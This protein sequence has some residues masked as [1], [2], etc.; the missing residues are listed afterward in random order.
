[1]CQSTLVYS[2]PCEGRLQAE[3][4]SVH[5]SSSTQTPVVGQALGPEI[6]QKTMLVSPGTTLVKTTLNPDPTP[7]VSVKHKQQFVL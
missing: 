1:M 3:N 6:V 5:Q 7:S 2:L 4:Q